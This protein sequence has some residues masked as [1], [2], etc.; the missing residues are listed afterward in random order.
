[1]LQAK[2]PDDYVLATNETH[3]IRDFL[4]AAFRHL[5]MDWREFVRFD[6]R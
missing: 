2:A 1:M 5:G 6:S 4:D 3:S